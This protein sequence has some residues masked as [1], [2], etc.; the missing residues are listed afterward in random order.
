MAKPTYRFDRDILRDER[1]YW[2]TSSMEEIVP[3]IEAA[4]SG[5]EIYLLM[6]FTKGP[7]TKAIY[8]HFGLTPQEVDVA[9][10][11]GWTGGCFALGAKLGK[12]PR[13]ETSPLPSTQEELDV[14]PAWPAIQ[15]NRLVSL[16]Q[17]GQRFAP[18]AMNELH[19]IFPAERVARVLHKLPPE[20]QE[21]LANALRA[22]GEP[23]PAIPH[24]S[25]S[26]PPPSVVASEARQH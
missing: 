9:E 26:V 25:S 5:Y 2:V 14:N 7:A 22:A 1:A 12:P 10:K 13:S 18:D 21:K 24:V 23:L 16:L 11:D 4:K 3:R 17:M 8:D 15:E 6:S 20:S 19:E